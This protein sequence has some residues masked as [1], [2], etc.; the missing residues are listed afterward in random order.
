MRGRVS[1]FRPDSSFVNVS[2]GRRRRP[3][4][5]ELKHIRPRV[6]AGDIELPSG[7]DELISSN[8]RVQNRFDLVRGTSYCFAVRINDDAVASVDPFTDIGQIL[9]LE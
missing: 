6:V 2:N 8:T 5:S 7:S 4:N 1:G 9:R 3:V